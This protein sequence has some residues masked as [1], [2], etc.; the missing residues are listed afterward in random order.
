MTVYFT[1]L[2]ISLFFAVY[3]QR[4][5]PFPQIRSSYITF[6]ILAALPFIFVTVF[7]YRVGRDWIYIYEPSYFLVNNGIQQFSEPLFNLIYRFFW[8]FTEDAYWVIAFIGLV[9]IVLFF[10]GICRES[11]SIP[12]SILIFFIGGTF[13][14]MLTGIRQ[15]LAASIFFFSVRYLKARDWKKYFLCCLIAIMIHTSA[16]TFV[17]LY[18]LYGLRATPGRCMVVML[19]AALGYPL[20]TVLLRFLITFTRFGARYIGRFYDTG[21]FSLAGF[22]VTLFTAGVHI[23][24]LARYRE[25]DR[26]FEWMSWVMVI[27]VVAELYSAAVPQIDRIV[28]GLNVVRILSLPVIYRKE[29]DDRWRVLVALATMALLAV[30]LFVFDMY[31]SGWYIDTPFQWVF[32]R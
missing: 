17:P 26:D 29:T 1:M 32:F 28:T 27:C 24:C 12:Y 23:F 31:I 15:M 16:I 20:F 30:K 8:L 9:T 18:F 25:P 19:L 14:F 7:R 2:A 22:L 11:A 5:K 13:F 4:A 6:C 21:N 10:V 3:A